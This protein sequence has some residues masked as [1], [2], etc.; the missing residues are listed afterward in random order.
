[1]GYL[2]NKKPN[3]SNLHI[4]GEEGASIWVQSKGK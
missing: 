2:K 1:M 3:K 4:R